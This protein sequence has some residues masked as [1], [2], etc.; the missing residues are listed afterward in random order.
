MREGYALG[1]YLRGLRIRRSRASEDT[2]ACA[3]VLCLTP[4]WSCRSCLSLS[5]LTPTL[6][7]GALLSRSHCRL[8]ALLPFAVLDV[9]RL[10]HP[11]VP[12]AQIIHERHGFTGLAVSQHPLARLLLRP[13][14]AAGLTLELPTLEVRPRGGV[15]LGGGARAITSRNGAGPEELELKLLYLLAPKDPGGGAPA[16]LY[17]VAWERQICREF[18]SYTA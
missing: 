4:H 7:E 2:A 16:V 5:F 10:L 15:L 18:G 12:K 11:P 8:T 14:R 1:S 9:H 3:S 13:W 6:Q 17:S